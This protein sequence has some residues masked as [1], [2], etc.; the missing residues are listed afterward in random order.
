MDCKDKDESKMVG[1]YARADSLSAE[2]RREIARKAA[3]ARWDADVPQAEHEGE[4][5]IGGRTIRAAVLPNG[6]RLLVQGTFLQ[7]IGRS[8]TPKAGTG[9][10][11]T[12]DGLPFFL[13]PDML[14]PFVTE[15]LRSS[16]TPIFFLDKSGKRSVAYDAQLLPKVASAYV[17]ARNQFIKNDEPLPRQYIHIFEQCD[18]IVNALAVV[19]IT[20]LVDE[21]TGYQDVRDRLALQEILDKYLRKEFAAWARCFPAEFYQEI[22][23][24]R[25]WAWKGMRVNRPQCVARYTM[26]LVYARLAKGI[27]DELESRNP[28]VNGKRKSPFYWWLTEDIGHP[29]LAQHLHAVIGLMRACDDWSQFKKM[30]DR[31]FPRRDDNQLKLDLIY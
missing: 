8:R 15:E 25:G 12:V 27:V 1:G 2:K 24:L 13:Q 6:K 31:A 10:M 21:A 17:K 22:F 16:T 19:G 5:N 29:A 28:M 9:V 7:A 26:D 20:A 30:I 3:H 4:F 18:I 23:R 14:K 11:A